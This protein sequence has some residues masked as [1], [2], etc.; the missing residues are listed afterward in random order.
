MNDSQKAVFFTEKPRRWKTFVGIIRLALLVLITVAIV[1]SFA[2]LSPTNLE[3][4]RLE[5]EKSAYQQI[6][7]PDRLAILEHEANLDFNRLRNR[8]PRE[9][10]L[11]YDRQIA[12][13]PVDALPLVRPIRS[14]FLQDDGDHAW[15]SLLTRI[16]S[17]NLVFPRWL[18]TPDEGDTVSEQLDQRAL[19]LLRV[20]RTPIVPVIT[21]NM[22]GRRDAG[23]ISRIMDEPESQQRFISSILEI[24]RREKFSGVIIHFPDL[25]KDDDPDLAI[26]LK[27]LAAA[28][29]PEGFLVAASLSPRQ[30]KSHLPEIAETADFVVLLAHDLH[31][32]DSAP[33]PI[34]PLSWV[35]DTVDQ[36]L[37]HVPREKLVVSV[38]TH[39]Y[40]WPDEEAGRLVSCSEVIVNAKDAEMSVTFNAN[41]SAIHTSY[42]D[43]KRLPH[44]VWCA[45]AVTAF[46]TLRLAA[47]RQVAGVVLSRL[48]GEDGRIWSFYHRQMSAESLQNE[49]VPLPLLEKPSVSSDIDYVGAGAIFEVV[50]R[51]APGRIALQDDPE[52]QTISAE[53]YLELPSPFIVRRYGNQPKKVLLS[54]DDGPDQIYTPQILDILDQEEVRA[55]FFIIGINAQKNLEIVRRMFD[56][57]HEIGNHTFTHPDL[58]KVSSQRVGFELSATRRLIECVTGHSTVLFR[59]PF[60]ADSEPERAVELLPVLEAQKQ[61]YLTVGESVDPRDW[62]PLVTTRQILERIAAEESL[63]NVILLHDAGGKRAETVKALPEIIK[64]F[65]D[66][67]CKFMTVAEAIGKTRDDVMPPLGNR[68]DRILAAF[69]WQVAKLLA[70]GAWMLSIL[71]LAAIALSIVRMVAI[72]ILAFIQKN[73]SARD[74][75]RESAERPFVSVIIPA[76]NEE[77]TCASTI[78]TLLAGDYPELEIVFVDDGSHDRTAEI[79]R[80]TFQDDTRVCLIT[81]QNGGKASALNYGVAR[82]KGDFLVC[83]DADTQLAPNA[84]SELMRGFSSPE[85]VAVAGNVKVGNE[86]NIL[87]RWQAIEYITSQG[88]DRRAFDLLNAIMVIP[89]AIGAFRKDAVMRAGCFSVDT[90]AEDCDLTVRLLR[91]GGIVRY[92]AG[93]IA[94]TEAPETLRSFIKQRFRWTFGIM[95]TVWKHR[96][97]A[98]SFR[99]KGLGLVALPNAILFQFGLT[100]IAPIADIGMIFSLAAGFWRDTLGYYLVFTLVDILGAALAFYFERERMRRLWLIIP[101]RFV[102]R[103]IMYIVLFK[104]LLAAIRGSL[105]GWN[106]L[107][108]TGHVSQPS[109][110]K[111]AQA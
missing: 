1:V 18:F 21:D 110:D 70:W 97:A 102:Y 25:G 47:D 85:V 49:P 101:Q 68:T 53:Q 38:A 105:V 39:G 72:A 48:G 93:A 104:S 81:K 13:S 50:S 10:E 84:V 8:L 90:L 26:F 69:N 30:C 88:F 42:L 77:V 28:L 23:N 29:K 82:A 44:E 6:L 4:P 96:D 91:R 2:I 12:S 19:Q 43:A 107:K 71:F 54:F 65:R 89:G 106:L 7:D 22:E 3:Q 66:K 62:E 80:Q 67:G 56:E 103:Q 78:R 45:D 108:R 14:A 17:L 64:H 35:R 74:T 100:L 83:I 34:S 55:T 41:D 109:A 73:R 31:T 24:L 36:V 99:Y 87:T 27:E 59:P 33:G 61:R 37:R 94:R 60:H 63:G 11:T 98:F 76:C 75:A 9:A 5:A 40:D 57:G 15:Y 32:A 16:D 92:Q 46:N 20:Y 86:G 52:H 79:V 58:S 95:Q 111:G 51:P